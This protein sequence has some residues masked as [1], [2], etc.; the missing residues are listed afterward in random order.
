MNLQKQCREC[1]KS[2][3]IF[4][5][6][7]E[8]YDKV[9][10]VFGG[11]KYAVPA[12][13]LCPRC[14]RQRRLAFRNERHLYH[15]KC[16]LTGKQ[17][18]SMY[19]PEKLHKVYSRD[20]WW[21]DKWDGLEYGREFDFSRPFFEQFSELLLAVPKASMAVFNNENS[22]YTNLQNDSKNCYLTFGCG[23]MED[24]M[25]SNWCYYAKN[26]VDC[27]FSSKSEL[28]YE[29]VD[30]FQ[31]YQCRFCRDCKNIRESLYCYDCRGCS[32]C[33]GCTGLR[34]KEYYIFNEPYSKEEYQKKVRELLREENQQMVLEKIRELELSHPRA[35]SRMLSC[36]ECTGDDLENSKNCRECF[37]VRA[38][39]DCKFNCDVLESKDQYDADRTGLSELCYEIC[40]GGYY[41]N[42]FAAF[43]CS[44]VN[45][46]QYI[47]ECTG[48]SNIFGCVGLQ[49]KQYCILNKQ[50]TKEE[51]EKLVPKI[52][53][54][55]QKTGEWGEFF[56][57][58]IS[59]FSYNETVAQ[60]YFPLTHEQV[61]DAG[62]RWR[63]EDIHSAYQ[64]P[65]PVIP[66]NIAEV[67]DDI[68]Q[69]ILLC[70][71]CGKHYKIIP[72]ELAFY[73]QFGISV[74][75]SCFN[76]RYRRRLALQNPRV[77]WDRACAKCGVNVR[78]TYAPER[79]E[80]I[81][82]ESCYLQAVY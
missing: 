73:R 63:D 29:N 3:E 54:H 61:I 23:F 50:Y 24:C 48:S 46:S 13:T 67:S 6:D 75:L 65:T 26:C 9:S 60:E 19:S 33:F 82:C 17:I 68:V 25:Y 80:I 51:Y 14:R 70:K 20:A 10:P 7:L 39:Q 11:V 53:A 71:T 18:I 32:N 81:Y 8:F 45:F 15:R 43:A 47:Y 66:W 27:S 21:S 12:P 69:Q 40:S 74:P 30:C 76:C 4:P 5:E 1:G 22:D 44:T 41:K 35:A 36:E 42:C 77:L 72:Q 58:A 55:M 31:T 49:R 34:K 79:K 52:I 16:D 57:A 38:S 28:D 62:F 56:P 37:G 2:F 64:G 59:T 78:T